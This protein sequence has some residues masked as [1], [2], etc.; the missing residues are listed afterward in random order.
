MLKFLYLSFHI[1]WRE[2]EQTSAFKEQW[3][4][5]WE[6]VESQGS[7]LCMWAAL[8]DFRDQPSQAPHTPI[9]HPYRCTTWTRGQ[10]GPQQGNRPFFSADWFIYHSLS[11]TYLIAWHHKASDGQECCLKKVLIFLVRCRDNLIIE[12]HWDLSVSASLVSMSHKVSISR[13][14][15]YAT[16]A[17]LASYLSTDISWGPWGWLGAANKR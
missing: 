9:L 8:S 5:T 16:L 13:W 2:V 3:S 15:C 10:T 7:P 11:F 6:T 1:S 17:H 14:L 12:M 4:R